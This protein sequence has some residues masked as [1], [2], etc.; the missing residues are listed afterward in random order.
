[1]NHF[2]EVTY[3]YFYSLYQ[4]F[5]ATWPITIIY[6]QIYKELSSTTREVLIESIEKIQDEST[7]EKDV[8]A[9]MKNLPEDEDLLSV[10]DRNNGFDVLQHSVIRSYKGVVCMLLSKRCNPDRYHCTPPVHLAAYL[11][12]VDLLKLLLH[13]GAAYTK[14]CGMCFPESHLPI[15]YASS[16]F[17]FTH[18]PVYK[19]HKEEITPIFCATVKN[20]VE[21]LKVLMEKSDSLSKRPS[22]ISLL[23]QACQAGAADSMKYFIQKYPECINQYGPNGDT[24]LL[25]A[26]RWGRECVKILVD[27]GADVH[28]ISKGIKETALHR[29]YRASSDGLFT[30]YDTTKYLLTTGIEQDI[31]FMT[32]L[33]E[34]PLHMLISHVSYIGGNFEDPS[35]QNRRSQVQSDY[36]EQVVNTCREILK[37]NADPHL[38]NAHGL[39]PLSRMLHIAL[40]SCNKTLKPTCVQ[41]ASFDYV[42]VDYRNDF[43]TLHK[44]MS[45]LLEYKADAGF[46]CSEGHTPLILLLQCLIYEDMKLL[47]Q[48]AEDVL[49]CVEVLVEN[50]AIVN[51]VAGND[52]TCSTIMAAICK[53][54]FTRETDLGQ[55]IS[56]ETR[57]EFAKLAND[58]LIVLF[59]YGLDPNHVTSKVSQYPRGGTG[60]ALIEFVRLTELATSQKD[61]S[62]I[63]MWLKTL[64]VWGANP[65]IEP[66]P[67]E[68]VIFHSQSSIFLKRHSTQP[69]NHYITEVKERESLFSDGHAEQ[70]LLLFYNTMD[71]KILFE[72]LN[73]TKSMVRFHLFD[74]NRKDFL[75]LINNLT[76]KPRSLRQMSRISIYRSL[77]MKIA[78]NVDKLPLPGALRQYMLDLQSP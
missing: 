58:I 30:I 76:E 32:S 50:G 73:V 14:A 36:Q 68:P 77:N 35:Q 29:L 60:N 43:N 12:D 71:H 64:F 22:P 13:S 31:N 48:Q 61:F 10:V 72:C 34:S 65:N 66:Y 27:N 52:V 69:V 74:D 23:L 15:S 16:Y 78:A 24:P 39:Q 41:T 70:L 56:E 49:H 59:K 21:C 4:Y 47:C 46:T 11:G 33:G 62:I 5:R 2:M 37:F 40:K 9:L 18:S 25:T 19:C 75:S 28:L 44:T 57:F 17:G 42:I 53:R 63:L 7:Q 54:Y 20:N 1:M 6:G 67:S 51:F 26:V 8:I 38:L 45:V 3:S 55:P